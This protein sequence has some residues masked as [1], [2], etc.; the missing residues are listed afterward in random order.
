MHLATLLETSLR[1]NR[2][3]IWGGR[4]PPTRTSTRFPRRAL[5]KLRITPLIR[6]AKSGPQTPTEARF[7]LLRCSRHIGRPKTVFRHIRSIHMYE[8][9]I[10]RTSLSS[11][12]QQTPR[13]LHDVRAAR[14]RLR[15]APGGPRNTDDEKN[16]PLLYVQ[17]YT[18]TH[19]HAQSK[20]SPLV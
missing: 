5:F 17:A 8:A 16:A 2:K 9:N 15:G 10:L 20:P 13:L 18:H 1:A 12:L 14:L 11:R 19:T 3:A 4:L 6:G 7:F